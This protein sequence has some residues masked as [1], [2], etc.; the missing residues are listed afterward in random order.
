MSVLPRERGRGRLRDDGAGPGIWAPI[1]YLLMGLVAVLVFAAA[2]PPDPVNAI[3]PDDGPDAAAI[4]EL[5]DEQSEFVRQWAA[6]I[7]ML[8][9]DAV[10]QAE[11]IAPDCG[12]GMISLGDDLFD[13]SDR[14]QLTEDGIRKLH[15]G[16]D[17]M[18][19]S[20]RSAPLVWNALEA[21]E[22]RGHADPRARRDPYVTNMRAS[23]QRPMSIMFYLISDWA[24]SER[25]REDL[26]N[27]LVLSAASHSRP[28]RT[29]PERSNECYPYW[30][31]VEISPRL[32]SPHLLAQLDGFQR[33]V[34]EL[35]PA[36][37]DSTAT[38]TATGRR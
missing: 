13:S 16:M 18:L 2:R 22:L 38:S 25:D 36:P 11:G 5:V 24:L 34:R 37:D 4:L 10:L 19:R 6:A 26:Q 21:I 30:R 28:P 32:K 12:S 7:S 31:R 29:C 1:S 20:L 3:V 14:N 9:S 17:I 8:C 35:I 23:Q 15:I 27:L 33:G